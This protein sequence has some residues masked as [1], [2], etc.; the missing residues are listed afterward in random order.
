MKIFIIARLRVM[1]IRKGYTDE[2]RLGVAKEAV[3][4][5]YPAL[6]PKMVA[7]CATIKPGQELST[8]TKVSLDLLLEEMRWK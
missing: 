6:Y 5:A 4:D 8:E 1:D 3:K 7:I 2:N